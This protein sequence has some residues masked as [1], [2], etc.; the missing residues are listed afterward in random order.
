MNDAK[1]VIQLAG[2]EVDLLMVIEVIP[3]LHLS[4]EVLL[5]FRLDDWGDLE[6]EVKFLDEVLAEGEVRTR[7]IVSDDVVQPTVGGTCQ[8]GFDTQLVRVE[9]QLCA[10]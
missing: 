1:Q 3:L 7:H 9:I 6:E 10:N 2:G 5:K 8:Q 4:Q